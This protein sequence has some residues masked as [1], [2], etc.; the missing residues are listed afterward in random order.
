MTHQLVLVL[1]LS[2]GPVDVAAVP[3]FHLASA[4]HLR[5]NTERV[6]GLREEER[7]GVKGSKKRG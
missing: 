2:L 7:G 1:E 6:R 4:L 5:V 3:G